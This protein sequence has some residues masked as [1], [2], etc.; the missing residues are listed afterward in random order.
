GLTV[1]TAVSQMIKEEGQPIVERWLDCLKAGGSM[2]P[3]E[4]L[5]HVGMDMSKP[6]AIRKA[7]TY[8]GSLIDELEQSYE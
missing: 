8:V 6:E 3:H 2:K 5:K 1:S 7:V 4:L